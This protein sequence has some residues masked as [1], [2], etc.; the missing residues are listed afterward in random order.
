MCSLSK[1]STRL[2]YILIKFILL[3]Q[4][5]AN[6]SIYQSAVNMSSYQ[7]FVN[8]KNEMLSLYNNGREF[9]QA[10]TSCIEFHSYD[11]LNVKYDG[12][13]IRGGLF[14]NGSNG[15]GSINIQSLNL[16][17]NSNSIPTKHNLHWLRVFVME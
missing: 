17:W 6:M 2:N 12:R 16:Y 8:K 5:V 14:G 15:G 13:I 9:Y 3:Y 7:I 10:H 4:T 11:S 1:S